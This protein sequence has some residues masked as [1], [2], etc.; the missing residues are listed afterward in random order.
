MTYILSFFVFYNFILDHWWQCIIIFITITL[1][2]FWPSGKSFLLSI[3]RQWGALSLP[4][5]VI[6]QF[7][8]K[9]SVSMRFTTAWPL[10]PHHSQY[11]SHGHPFKKERK[12]LWLN[13]I[14]TY[15]WAIG[16]KGNLKSSSILI[17]ILNLLHLLL[18]LGSHL[19]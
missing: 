9:I 19:V 18:L 15:L 5:S 16:W 13:I 4:F 2:F 14:W 10:I 6:F 8:N 11:Y 17:V 3:S 1:L 12:M 7:I